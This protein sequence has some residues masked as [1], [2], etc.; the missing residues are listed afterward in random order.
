MYI[1]VHW[2]RERELTSFENT[3]PSPRAN[4]TLEAFGVEKG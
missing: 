3:P 2:E 1:Y 4:Y